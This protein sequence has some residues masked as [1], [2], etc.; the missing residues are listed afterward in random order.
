MSKNVAVYTICKLIIIADAMYAII[1]ALIA[2]YPTAGDKVTCCSDD[3]LFFL[4]GE[5][6]VVNIISA[7]RSAVLPIS[8]RMYDNKNAP[9][10][11]RQ[12]INTRKYMV[13]SVEKD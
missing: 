3:P 5:A 2:I 7:A 11:N 9:L 10:Q 6:P 12:A 4:N 13:N 8:K 1:D